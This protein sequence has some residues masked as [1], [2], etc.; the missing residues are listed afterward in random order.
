MTDRILAHA[1]PSEHSAEHH[2]LIVDTIR[3]VLSVHGP[4]RSTRLIPLVQAVWSLDGR[5]ARLR[6]SAQDVRRLAVWGDRA[7]FSRS[8]DGLVGLVTPT[9]P[10]VPAAS[11]G[12]AE[13]MLSACEASGIDVLI[14]A[15]WLLRAS[16]PFLP[17]P[18]RAG[19]QTA[20]VLNAPTPTTP[21]CQPR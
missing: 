3:R 12:P 1:S 11:A 6:P 16:L 2:T 18:T 19:E 10:A 7:T 20:P 21:P 13:P 14:E 17:A 5:D 15:A 9:A 4:L 8:I